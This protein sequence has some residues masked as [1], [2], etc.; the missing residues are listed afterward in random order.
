MLNPSASDS[1]FVS[2]KRAAELLACS[3]Q[4]ISKLI[5]DG[6]L[7]AYHL[8]RAVRIKLSDLE[9]AMVAYNQKP[10]VVTRRVQ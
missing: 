7:P 3:A 5:K 2:R 1:V 6:R 9:A 8:G 10:A 4:M